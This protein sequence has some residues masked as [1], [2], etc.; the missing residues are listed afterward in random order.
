MI[1]KICNK[2]VENLNGLSLHL[3]KHNISM[4]EY[5]DTY[6]DPNVFHKCMFCDNERSFKKGKYLST[7]CSEECI[8]KLIESVNMEK[9]GCKNVAQNASVRAKN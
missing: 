4:K 1:C 3:R 2:N 8:K 7:C 6:I 5:Y 9:Y